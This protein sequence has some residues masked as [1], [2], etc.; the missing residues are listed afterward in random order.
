MQKERIA[1]ILLR[2]GAVSLSPTSPFQY[3]SGIFSPI[4]TDCRMLNS[5]PKERE[6][7]ID[8]MIKFITREVGKDNI[9]AIIGTAHSG[10]SL[11]T[12]LAH[13]L[14]LPAGYIRSSAK[15]YGK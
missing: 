13:R 2:I 12:Y 9:D 15:E 11:A 5:Y 4:Y 1:Q 6:T 8:S 7:I 14:E 3:A 10:V